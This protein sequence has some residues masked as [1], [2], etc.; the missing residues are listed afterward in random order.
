MSD[1]VFL[2]GYYRSGTSA[3]AG[4]LNYLGVTFEN[5]VPVDKFNPVGFYEIARL[6]EFDDSIFALF[7]MQWA[8]IRTLSQRWWLRSDM[9]EHLFNLRNILGTILHSPVCGIK[10]PY[11]CRLLPMYEHAIQSMPFETHK[12]FNV[13]VTR[14]PWVAGASQMHKNGLSRSHALLLWLIYVIEAE[15]NT[16]HLPRSWITYD[17][18]MIN[19]IKQFQKIQNET[20]LQFS[21]FEAA[22]NSIIEELNHKLILPRVGVPRFLVSLIDEVW[23][24]IQAENFDPDTWQD[25]ETACHDIGSLVVDMGK[26]LRKVAPGV[27]EANQAKIR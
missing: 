9:H 25:F 11:H 27:S 24:A 2:T 14:S 6:I 3:L 20:G 7:G 23:A 15:R 10:H 21:N 19:P 12:I 4:A 26:S 1:I 16:R 13:G 17:N 5:D 22:K 8:D 18:L